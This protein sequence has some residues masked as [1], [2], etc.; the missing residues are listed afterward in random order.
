MEEEKKSDYII[1]KN[2]KT[3]Y[4]FFNGYGWKQLFITVLGALFG[5]L[6]YLILGLF[7]HSPFRVVVIALFGTVGAMISISDPRT[8]KNIIS[9][10][11]DYKK[12]NTTPK[13][14]RYKFGEGRDSL[15]A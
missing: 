14:Y 10:F 13:R 15:D 5:G 9:F 12:F 8:G 11:K 7:I 4:E 1:P 3:P 6:I 2:V